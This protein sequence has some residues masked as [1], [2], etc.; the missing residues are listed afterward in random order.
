MRII[1]VNKF[2]FVKGGAERYYLDLSASLS[3]RGFEVD[4]L[5][6]AH[7][8]LGDSDKART[9]YDRAVQ[10]MDRQTPHDDELRRFRAEAE[11]VLAKAGKR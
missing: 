3:R 2:H 4:H 7:G 1:Q 10:W 6:M 8:R 9:W 5:A 11:A